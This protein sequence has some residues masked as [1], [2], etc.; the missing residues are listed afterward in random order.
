MAPSSTITRPRVWS[1]TGRS[2]DET[3]IRASLRHYPPSSDY[4]IPGSR[5]PSIQRLNSEEHSIVEAED[6]MNMSFNDTL[7]HNCS[8]MSYEKLTNRREKKR[9]SSREQRGYHCYDNPSSLDD[10]CNER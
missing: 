8:F 5:H 9:R 4:L 3:T 1:E 7:L 2:C 6:L 10:E